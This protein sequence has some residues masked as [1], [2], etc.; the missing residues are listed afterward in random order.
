MASGLNGATG[1]RRLYKV[2]A[3]RQN[4]L[5][6]SV[7]FPILVCEYR[8]LTSSKPF[9]ILFTAVAAAAAAATDRTD[10]AEAAAR[11]GFTESSAARF[12]PLA[13][14]LIAPVHLGQSAKSA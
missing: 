2:F 1:G 8:G 5:Q 7:Q 10:P 13:H 9:N 12:R 3:Q 11:S 4:A 6:P 14:S